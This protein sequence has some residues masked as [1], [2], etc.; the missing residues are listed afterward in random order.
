M[1][2]D[3]FMGSMKP[4]YAKLLKKK[5]TL[6]KAWQTQICKI[7]T[8]P[9]NLYPCEKYSY[10]LYVIDSIFNQWKPLSISLKGN[11]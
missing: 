1:I 7:G 4:K 2:H 8:Y 9:L 11:C 3:A 6:K 10:F 5:T